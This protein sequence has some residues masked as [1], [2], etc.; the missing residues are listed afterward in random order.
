MAAKVSAELGNPGVVVSLYGSSVMGQGKTGGVEIETRGN[1]WNG[2]PQI[3]A[4][5]VNIRS[6]VKQPGGAGVPEDR[7]GNPFA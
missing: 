3:A 2:M 1:G 6:A 5:Q 7:W 4:Y